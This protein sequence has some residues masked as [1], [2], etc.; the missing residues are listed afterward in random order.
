MTGSGSVRLEVARDRDFRQRRRAQD[1]RHERRRAATRSRRAWAA[2]RPD[3]R[4]YYRFETRDRHSPVG[5][6][7]TAL[8]ADSNRPVKFAFFSCAEYTHGYYNASR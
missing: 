4:Y 6:F 3:E 5:R 1:D 2:C 8:P 7:Q